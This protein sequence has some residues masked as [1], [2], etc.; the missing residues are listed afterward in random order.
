LIR[1]LI[2]I[3]EASLEIPKSVNSNSS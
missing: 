2:A 1:R 3:K